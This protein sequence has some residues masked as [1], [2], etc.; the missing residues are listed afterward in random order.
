MIVMHHLMNAVAIK[1]I[2]GIVKMGKMKNLLIKQMDD[3]QEVYEDVK[4]LFDDSLYD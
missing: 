4:E 2:R 1:D 3:E